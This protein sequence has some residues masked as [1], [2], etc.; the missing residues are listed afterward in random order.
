LLIII[1]HFSGKGKV[2]KFHQRRILKGLLSKS[3]DVQWRLAALCYREILYPLMLKIKI[4]IPPAK[5]VSAIMLNADYDT[6]F[7]RLEHW[8]GMQ[9]KKNVFNFFSAA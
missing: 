4:P 2:L 6:F 3:I 7:D 1:N 5:K 8:K 9:Q